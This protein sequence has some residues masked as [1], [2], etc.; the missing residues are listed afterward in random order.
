MKSQT[1]DTL[2]PVSIT[3]INRDLATL[4]LMLNKA[5]EQGKYKVAAIQI[6][7]NLKAKKNANASSLTQTVATQPNSFCSALDRVRPRR[8]RCDFSRSRDT[9]GICRFDKRVVSM[10][11]FSRISFSFALLTSIYSIAQ[12]H[13]QCC[14]ADSQEIILLEEDRAAQ[15]WQS[16]AISAALPA[17]IHARA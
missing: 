12:N 15:A 6:R 5:R 7:L 8:A 17:S 11:K 3:T 9:Y 16:N 14:C 1:A 10:K 2:Q 13:L 4:R